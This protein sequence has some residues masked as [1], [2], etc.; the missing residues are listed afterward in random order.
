MPLSVPTP[1]ETTNRLLALGQG[2]RRP[3]EPLLW[4]QRDVLEL[5][6]C[7]L[8]YGIDVSS[9]DTIVLLSRSQ[10]WWPGLEAR[11]DACDA[12][13]T[14]HSNGN[15]SRLGNPAKKG[16]IADVNGGEDGELA[17]SPKLGFL[18]A[19][20][21]LACVCVLPPKQK[22]GL[23]MASDVPAVSERGTQR[24]AVRDCQE[25]AKGKYRAPL[26][27]G[28]VSVSLDT[29]ADV[30]DTVDAAVEA[31]VRHLLSGL[32]SSSSQEETAEI[33]MQVASALYV[34]VFV[35]QCFWC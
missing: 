17:I 21:Q 12:V 23:D 9:A 11:P 2:L 20:H 25:E 19:M 22:E 34:C 6:R 5:W 7:C 26:F 16:T 14:G 31:C 13:S 27:Q 18:R 15:A 29:W 10:G 24:P 33:A 4:M 8:S 3:R 1:D 28:G 35:L 30:G 32:R